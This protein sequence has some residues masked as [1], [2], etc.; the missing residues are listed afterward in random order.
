MQEAKNIVM[1]CGDTLEVEDKIKTVIKETIIPETL[2]IP[3]KKN[4][5][6]KSLRRSSTA[7]ISIADYDEEEDEDESEPNWN[8]NRGTFTKSEPR[9]FVENGYD[10]PYR[11]PRLRRLDMRRMTMI[12]SEAYDEWDHRGNSRRTSRSE[13]GH[14]MDEDRSSRNGYRYSNVGLDDDS[15]LHPRERYFTS[16][17]YT[18]SPMRDLDAPILRRSV[19]RERYLPKE[20]ETDR[21]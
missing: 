20:P 8:W 2:E 17:G 21:R 19:S 14:S 9:E 5:V 16:G 10:E 1:E 12:R 15:Y 18:R 11:N 13:E 7:D 3:E 4:N 6:K